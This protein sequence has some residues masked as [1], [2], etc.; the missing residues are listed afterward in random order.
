MPTLVLSTLSIA[1]DRALADAARAAG[2]AVHDLASAPVEEL[3]PPVV[4]YVDTDV[5]LNAAR[6]LKLALLE[7]PLDL[8]ARLPNSY[9]L[10]TVEFGKYAALSRLAGR[11]FV[12][13]ADPLGKVFD[14]GIYSCA[15][16][17]RV[18]RPIDPETPILVAE[19]VEWVTEYR[20]FVLERKVVAFSPYIQFGRPSWKPWGTGGVVPQLPGGVA[21]VCRRLLADRSVSLLPAFVVDVGLIEERGWAVVEFNPAWSAGLLGANPAEVL[22][23]LARACQSAADLDETEERWVI[24]RR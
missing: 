20:C 11:A 18:R 23:V 24:A 12:K 2:W 17:I 15:Q 21:E 9:R 16:D 4:V 1:A 6:L 14:A 10:R 7:P 19:P 5:A 8:L 13:P 3:E 22:P